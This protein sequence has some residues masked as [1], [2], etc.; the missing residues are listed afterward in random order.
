IISLLSLGTIFAYIHEGSN[1]SRF[2]VVL[3]AIPIAI[4]ANILRISSILAIA[5]IYGSDTA[6]SFFHN[7]SGFLSFGLALLM[8]FAVGRWFGRLKVRE[9]L[10]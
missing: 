2:L 1:L 9:E 5:D 6:I 10:F 3:S 7:F 8:L 4:F